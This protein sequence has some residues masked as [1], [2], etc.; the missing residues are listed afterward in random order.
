MPRY[1][2]A[3]SPFAPIR[4]RVFLVPSR[5]SGSAL[6][7]VHF[8]QPHEAHSVFPPR[9][10]TRGYQ[11]I[12]QGGQTLFQEKIDSAASLHFRLSTRNLESIKND[13]TSPLL[14]LRIAS[15]SR[16]ICL[17]RRL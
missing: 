12:G 3:T 2:P 7:S 4:L 11:V 9:Q 17:T 13:S 8:R 6:V 5:R 14:S 1:W 16:S 10:E 15:M